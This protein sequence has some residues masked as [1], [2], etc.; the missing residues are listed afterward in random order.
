MIN[1]KWDPFVWNEELKVLGIEY[2]YLGKHS[3]SKFIIL[4]ILFPA[5]IFLGIGIVIS[6][7]VF[8]GENL[9]RMFN[10]SKKS[11]TRTVVAEENPN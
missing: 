4:Y 9:S 6:S 5:L 10:S 11:Q 7:I 1:R 8:I 2:F 3:F